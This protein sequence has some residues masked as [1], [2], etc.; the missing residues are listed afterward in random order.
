MYFFL[1]IR[2]IRNLTKLKSDIR[3]LTI[4]IGQKLVNKLMNQPILCLPYIKIKFPLL[5]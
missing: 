1:N 5:F 4:E 3:N 2:G